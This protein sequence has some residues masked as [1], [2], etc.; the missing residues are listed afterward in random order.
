VLL[1]L[2]LTGVQPAF[3]GISVLLSEKDFAGRSYQVGESVRVSWAESDARTL[4]PGATRPEARRGGNS[5]PR[6]APLAA[7]AAMAA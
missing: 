7:L 1:G 4:G 3:S 2:R 5:P 6:Q